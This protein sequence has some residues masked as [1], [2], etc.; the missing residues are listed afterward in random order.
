MA[1]FVSKIGHSG[2][3]S[4]RKRVVLVW[5]CSEYTQYSRYRS[6]CFPSF[7][8]QSPFSQWQL[9]GNFC[10]KSIPEKSQFQVS[11]TKKISNNKAIIVSPTFKIDITNCLYFFRFFTRWY[12]KFRFISNT[13]RTKISKSSHCALLPLALLAVLAVELLGP[14][15]DVVVAYSDR[16][17]FVSAATTPPPKLASAAAFGCT[18]VSNS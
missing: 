16:G 18:V 11:E 2:L 13:F 10:P 9:I 1:Y 8:P 4:S 15:V 3:N 5:V 17:C 14:G 7:P 12:L 6:K